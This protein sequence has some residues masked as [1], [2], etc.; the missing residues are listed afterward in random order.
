V[1]GLPNRLL[2]YDRVSQALAQGQRFDRVAA[3]IVFDIDMFQRIND[4]LGFVVGDKLLKKAAERLVEILRSTDTV[5]LLGGST[6]TPTVS[7]TGADEF[8]ILI[9]DLKDADMVTWIVKRILDSMSAPLAIDSHEI[10]ITCSA[11]ISLYPH[12]GDTVDTLLQNANAAR[13]SAKQRLGRNNFAFYSTDLNQESYK[14]LWFESQLHH[15]LELG[16]LYLHYQ[17]KVDLRTGRITSMEALVRWTNEKL[18]FVSPGDFIPVAERTG[19]INEIGAWVMRAACNEAKRW[20]DAGFEDVGIA[21]NLSALQ[22]RQD[23]LHAQIT[24]T[25]AESGLEP[26][27]LEVEIT[28]TAVMEDFE[29]AI[30]TLNALTSAGIQ[31]SVDDF[32]TGYSSLAYLKHLPLSTLKIDRSFLSD[33]IPDQQDELIITAIIAMAHS[34]GLRVVAEGVESNA[35]KAFLAGLGCDEIQGYLISKPVPQQEALALLRT[36]NGA[37]LRNKKDLKTA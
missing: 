14:H 34:M 2:F 13:F 32:G 15:A 18:G 27:L 16:E 5:A 23:D 21:V 10:F 30:K 26:G 36:H 37:D 28:E 4:A 31:L 25:L 12:D 11:G 6:K 3:V 29:R 9:T 7:R 19:L 35:Q 20:A 8:G 17:P 1:T 22:F 33:S 24:T